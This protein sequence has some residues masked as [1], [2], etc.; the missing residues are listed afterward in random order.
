M[1]ERDGRNH[2]IRHGPDRLLAA[3]PPVGTK[4]PRD[5]MIHFAMAT[6]QDLQAVAQRGM[7]VTFL[8]P[9]LC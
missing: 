8:T 7:G 2:F 6:K 4:A 9:D 1:R 3:L 5:V